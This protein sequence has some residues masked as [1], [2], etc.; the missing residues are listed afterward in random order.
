MMRLAS[1]GGSRVPVIAQLMQ[2]DEDFVV[3]TAAARPMELGRSFTCWSLRRLVA[4]PQ[5]PT[6]GPSASAVRRSWTGS[7]RS[8]AFSGRAF[9]FDGSNRS[10]SVLPQA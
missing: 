5:K 7:R 3:Q 9:T 4:Y 1:A 2:A 8:W 6:A 10:E